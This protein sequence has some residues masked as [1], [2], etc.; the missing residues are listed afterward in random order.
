[1]SDLGRLTIPGITPKKIRKNT[2]PRE[3]RSEIAV[4]KVIVERGATIRAARRCQN[5]SWIRS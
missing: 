5:A 3:I 4:Q 2:F 1:M